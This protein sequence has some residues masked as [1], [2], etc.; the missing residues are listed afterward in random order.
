MH[1]NKKT[2]RN[3]SSLVKVAF[4]HIEPE[5]GQIEAN[6]RLIEKGIRLAAER[7][8]SWVVTPELATSG[9]FFQDEIGTDWIETQPDAWMKRLLELS[10]HYH[11]TIFLAVPERDAGSGKLYNATFILGPEGKVTGRHRK[12]NIHKDHSAESCFEPG[13]P[14][15]VDAFSCNGIKAGILICADSWNAYCADT[16]KEKGAQL[17]VSPAAWPLEPC[18]PEGCWERRSAETGL[19]IWVCNRTG[20]EQMLDF[21]KAESIVA[22]RGERRLSAALEK[23]AVLFFDWDMKAMEPLS[24]EF[25]VVYL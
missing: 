16:L 22:V 19:P 24:N 23:S 15:E 10:R 21:K 3:N 9:F 8:A 5:L 14:A 18:G 20:E 25:E 12:M 6:R 1:P 2:M 11:L 4:L 7:G 17:L 13:S